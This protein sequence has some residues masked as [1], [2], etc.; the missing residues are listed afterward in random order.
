[1]RRIASYLTSKSGFSDQFAAT[2]VGQTILGQAPSYTQLGMAAL[3]PHKSLGYASS[4]SS[5]TVDTVEAKKRYIVG[6]N[7]AEYMREMRKQNFA[8]AIDRY[9]KLGNNLN[10]RDVIAVRRTVSG[11]LK[12][13]H[14][15]SFACDVP[16][17]LLATIVTTVLIPS[18][19]S[20]LNCCHKFVVAILFSQFW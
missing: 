11:L 4:G 6:D 18:G 2:A 14:P 3:L 20:E 1:M 13:L 19:N 17:L 5:V 16:L 12:L 7:L 15:R 9:F 10:Q 8:D